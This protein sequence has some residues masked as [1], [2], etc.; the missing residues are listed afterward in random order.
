MGRSN[1]T[2][3]N[4]RK[5]LLSDFS[6]THESLLGYIVR[7]TELNR[8]D[9]PAWITEEARLSN[10]VNGH[11]IIAND[12]VD[13][14]R[15]ARLSGRSATDLRI[16]LYQSADGANGKFAPRIIYSQPVPYYLLRL[17]QPKICSACLGEESYCRR[18]WDLALVTTCPTHR[19][20]LIDK[21][22]ECGR[23]IS[24][25]RN[26]VSR[27]PDP[28]GYSWLGTTLQSVDDL[29]LKVTQHIYYLCGNPCNKTLYGNQ[30]SAS[31]LSNLRLDSFILCLL[32][33]GS[34]LDNSRDIMSKHLM[35]SSDN[36]KVN[37]LV[38]KALPVFYGWP[39]N[40][41]SF[42][43]NRQVQNSEN[44]FYS[45]GLDFS[46]Y[47][48]SL[49]KYLSSKCFDF[50]RAAFEEYVFMNW[51]GGRRTIHLKQL[52]SVPV[53]Q[54]KYASRREAEKLLGLSRQLVD[55]YIAVG[56]LKVVIK[57][58]GKGKLTPIETASILQLKKDREQA[59]SYEQI[60]NK[61]GLSWVRVKEVVAGGLLKTLCGSTVNVVE[62]KFNSLEV[63]ALKQRIEDKV[64]S[65]LSI[66]GQSKFS[67][68]RALMS[69]GRA[70]I[71]IDTL[72]RSI[73]DGEV[74]PY[75]KLGKRLSGLTFLRKSIHEL[76]RRI[77][78]RQADSLPLKEVVK[79]WGISDAAVRHFIRVGFLSAKESRGMYLIQKSNVEIFNS[80]YILLGKVARTVG[81]DSGYLTEVLLSH[82]IQ[83]ISGPTID[84]GYVY[85]FKKNEIEGLD[86]VELVTR[87][88]ANSLASRKAPVL[89][90]A[91][92]VAKVLGVD[93]D[94][95]QR[96]V[97]NGILR[98]YKRGEYKSQE[99]MY[100]TKEMVDRLKG[101]VN[102]T[103]LVS[104]K[105]AAKMLEV[106]EEKFH[107]AY[108]R[109]GRLKGVIGSKTQLHYYAQK[110]IES[111]IEE[112]NRLIKSS[113]AARI[114]GTSQDRV[115]DLTLRGVL[116]PVR[117]PRVDG[118]HHY[119]YV[120]SDVERLRD[121]KASA[122]KI[123]LK[124]ALSA[125][126]RIR[127]A[128]R[129][130]PAQEKI[131]FRVNHIINEWK[132]TYPEQRLSVHRIYHQ[133][134]DEGCHVSLS[135]VYAY[136]R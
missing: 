136:L 31:P 41:F 84:G 108:I 68:G 80:S 57:N 83:A 77:W 79:L 30:L 24:W 19:C 20:L 32:F 9:R 48:Y 85:L 59:L 118:H 102:Y 60:K 89:A 1:R 26:S 63:K 27:C 111:L 21:C 121:E 69:L 122:K 127:T 34:Q 116:K 78:L 119:F 40:F 114:L 65:P 58:T 55:R 47:R 8:Y 51:D 124:R 133:L 109:S 64:Q 96:L 6:G 10:I 4:N 45:S 87:A 101:D 115:N 71:R 39:N 67:L 46:T 42:L 13:L 132:T 37:D 134:L 97:E 98:P 11:S 17:R 70:N 25:N 49:Y 106:S 54:R 62:W 104:T 128:K 130:R 29:A 113:E 99:K 120:R 56:R 3:T 35:L 100:F 50:L 86:L 112:K 90:D 123:F 52:L 23:R 36:S 126:S 15:L 43:N 74:I 38:T 66:P 103:G 16:L 125:Q 22:P 7:L 75:G 33:I 105:V 61:L 73:L 18:I 81:T 95:I 110:D 91:L 28:C 5:L 107:K 93:L 92:L 88:K 2:V 14:E 12:A 129:S 53:Q 76:S 131:G 72:I 94:Y 117:G 135:S 82:G 44:E